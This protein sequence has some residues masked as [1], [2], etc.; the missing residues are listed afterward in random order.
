MKAYKKWKKLNENAKQNKHPHWDSTKEKYCIQSFHGERGKA[1]K[2]V[3]PLTVPRILRPLR[4]GQR[5]DNDTEQQQHEK[6]KRHIHFVQ[7]A[8]G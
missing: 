4:R 3:I 2:I 8:G 6:V 5:Q 7:H 1:H